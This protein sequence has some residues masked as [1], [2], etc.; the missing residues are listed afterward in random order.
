M[1]LLLI[2]S[3]TKMKQLIWETVSS[4]HQAYYNSTTVL[5][6]GIFFFLLYVFSQSG[7]IHR[8]ASARETTSKV[9]W[10]SSFSPSVRP[11][12]IEFLNEDHNLM[13]PVHW[14]LQ[15]VIIVVVVNIKEK[16]KTTTRR[17][18]CMWKGLVFAPLTTT[19]IKES[20]VYTVTSYDAEVVSPLPKPQPQLK[21][22][23]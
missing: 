12:Y 20:S 2:S 8:Q 4:N 16:K 11:L 7:E 14:S 3:E 6:R 13:L 18:A 19:A 1:T 9:L 17:S 10:Q 22:H 21:K 15:S 5:N 23:P